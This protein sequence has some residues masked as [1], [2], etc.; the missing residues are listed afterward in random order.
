MSND[1]VIVGLGNPGSRYAFTRHNIGF[2]L[3]DLIAQDFGAT[4]SAKGLGQKS[5]SEFCEVNIAGKNALLLKPQ[6]FMNLSGRSLMKL[7]QFNPELRKLDLIVAH[8]EVDLPYAQVRIKRG[9]S[10]AGHNGLKSLR[11]ELGNGESIRIRMGVGRPVAGSP[12]SVAEY[13]L[14]K[15]PKDEGH[16]LEELLQ[17]SYR[18]LEAY[19][20]KG[21][22]AAQ[23]A[24]GS[25]DSADD[26]NSQSR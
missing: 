2:I 9:G 21:L 23:M 7:Y 26:K 8:D 16:K 12:I 14:G 13:V 5:E 17:R 6:T 19:L 4:F 11:Q 25:V 20:S 10:D 22:Q 18:G 3:L 1:V 24:V 15:F